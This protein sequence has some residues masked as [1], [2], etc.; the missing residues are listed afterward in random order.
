MPRRPL[1]PELRPLREEDFPAVFEAFAAAFSDYLVPFNFTPEELREMLIRRGYVPELSVG[2]FQG[3][4]M[5]GFTLT[6]RGSWN[7]KPAAYDTGTGVVPSHRRR[8]I[9]GELVRCALPLF[10]RAGIHQVVLEVLTTNEPAY[11]LYLELGF[12]T[13]RRL[14]CFSADPEGDSTAVRPLEAIPWEIVER[15]HEAVPSWQ[16]GRES[17]LRARTPP[18]LLG[19][20]AEGELV[21]YAAVFASGDLPQ[22]AVHPE[23]RRRGF[24]SRLLRAARV[25][26]GQPLRII[27]V[28]S[29]ATGVLEFLR[30][31]G[32]R[33][34]VEQWEMV[35]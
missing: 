3:R 7:G 28:D 23:F 14:L 34:T 8:G 31:S 29:E 20:E 4:R 16:N 11:R 2:A 18:I 32:A 17:L 5:V 6:G 24:G 21:G 27:N 12:R 35:L 22:L 25:V 13:A 10:E 26:A 30:A 33:N 19:I 1:L 9:G 15:W